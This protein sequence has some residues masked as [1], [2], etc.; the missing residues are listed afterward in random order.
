MARRPSSSS[1]HIINC[2]LACESPLDLFMILS[3]RW[4]RLG[5]GSHFWS[6]PSTSR[7]DQRLQR[8]DRRTDVAALKTATL[9]LTGRDLLG[10]SLL[11]LDRDYG[12][13]GY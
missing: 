11:G 6:V 3:P 5:C 9:E 1:F 13:P 7:A 8:I 2:A 12:H 4:G 10:L